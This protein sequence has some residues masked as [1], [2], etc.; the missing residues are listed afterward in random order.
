MPKQL[1]IRF[2]L[3]PEKVSANEFSKVVSAYENAIV[4]V[5]KKN[6]PHRLIP[7]HI[8]V[9]G[10]E[11]DDLGIDLKPNS[12]DDI[13]EAAHEI[14][15]NI[16]NRTFNKLP[17]NAVENLNI[18]QRFINEKGVTAYLNGYEG[19]AS[20]QITSE[21][22]LEVDET[23]YLQGETTIYGKVVRIGGAT[24]K[25]RIEIDKNKSISIEVKT[26]VAKD[27]SSH[28][29]E[30]VAITGL[31]KWK[32]EDNELVDLKFIS[33]K[34]LSKKSLTEKLKELK[35]VIGKHW[36]NIDNPDE[37]LAHLRGDI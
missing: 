32:K 26:D 3:P 5:V 34:K 14:N 35:S 20:S 4:S 31:A 1:K 21:T 10:V 15:V 13:F 29:Y 9:T 30:T 18:I 23:F 36:D 33:H 7:A 22:N 25:V 17:I 12:D 24:P 2:S 6:H 19:I 37:H 11:K 27:L 8:S 16:S 28:L